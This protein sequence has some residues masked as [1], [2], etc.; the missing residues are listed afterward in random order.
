LA[1]RSIQ[2]EDIPL[3][4]HLSFPFALALLVGICG[5]C[6]ADSPGRQFS[7][8]N[9][10]ALNLDEAEPFEFSVTATAA[11][12]RV[13]YR[14]RVKRKKGN[15]PPKL[16]VRL[17][18]VDQNSLLVSCLVA[19]SRDKSGLSYEFSVSRKHLAES[20]LII[21]DKEYV[22][23]EPEGGAYWF[24]LTDFASP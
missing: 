4:R 24:G 10:K 5:I 8:D 18:V 15:V 6:L 2:N 19:E 13:Q 1:A 7:A 23:K 20:L 17:N 3:Q 21:T 11:G 14:V 9:L 12:S 22:P 16:D